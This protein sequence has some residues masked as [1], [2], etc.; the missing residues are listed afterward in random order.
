MASQLLSQLQSV[1]PADLAVM[2]GDPE[3]AYAFKADTDLPQ[4]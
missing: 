4:T 2:C 1:T 3:L